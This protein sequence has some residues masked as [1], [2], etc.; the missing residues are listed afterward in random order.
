ML[1]HTVHDYL[2]CSYIRKGEISASVTET[3]TEAVFRFAF[4]QDENCVTE[5][6]RVPLFL[7][8]LRRQDSP[9]HPQAQRKKKK[10]IFNK[11]FSL[12][13][14][15][16]LIPTW[17]TCLKAPRIWKRYSW[18]ILIHLSQP[19]PQAELVLEAFP[20]KQE[21]G[22]L[23]KIGFI[24][25]PGGSKMNVGQLAINILVTGV[26]GYLE[27]CDKVCHMSRIDLKVSIFSKYLVSP[28][29]NSYMSEYAD[30]KWLKHA[31]N[32]P[33]IHPC[34]QLPRILPVF[35]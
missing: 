10:L 3:P 6:Q 13:F 27:F 11:D 5:I 2:C 7:G 24:F 32:M 28:K 23:K 30:R 22:F 21:R 9:R 14:H 17:A 19:I 8:W 35:L 16:A 26:R 4:I 31:N 34:Y 15:V 12:C 29:I 18:D 33:K 25:L 1:M 20:R